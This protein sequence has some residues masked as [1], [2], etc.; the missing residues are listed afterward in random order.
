MEKNKNLIYKDNYKI[1][2]Q[3]EN[4]KFNNVEFSYFNSDDT[5]FNKLNLEIPKNSHTLVMGPN[6]SGKS[7]LLGLISGIYF[8]SKGEVN[9][10]SNKLGFIG[11]NPL[12]FDGTLMSNIQYGNENK[13]DEEVVIEYLKD[14]ETF[15]EENNY[16]L[17]KQITNKTLSSGQMQKIAFIRALLSNIEIL[18]LDESTAN[19]DD[20]AS[21]KIF[22]ILNESNLTIINCTHDQTKFPNAQ[23]LVKIEVTDE[24]RNVTYNKMNK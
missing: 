11:P 3:S 5:I 8:P 13:L 10:F 19:L 17:T 15:K 6:G 22:E 12:I 14:L 7:T 18:L 23:G 21:K 9:I 20:K 2:K 16:D 1:N 24:T 4:I